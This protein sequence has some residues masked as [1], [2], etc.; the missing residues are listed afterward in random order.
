MIPEAATRQLSLDIEEEVFRH[1]MFHKSLID[2][3]N[4]DMYSRL[5]T[6]LGVMSQLKEGVHVTIKDSY[7]RSIAMVLELATEEYMDPWDVDLVRFCRMFLKKLEKEDRLNLVVIGKLIRMAYTV[8]MLKSATTLKKAEMVPQEEEMDEDQFYDWMEDDE[9]FKV[10]RGILG[11]KHSP[12]A[13]SIIHKGDRPVTLV[14]LLNALEDVQDEVQVLQEDRRRRVENRKMQ[15]LTNRSNINQKVFKENTE[16]EI[17]LT[18]Q[19]IN[20]FNGHPIPLS[21]IEK[22]FELDGSSIFISLLF[23]AYNSMIKVWQRSF[24]VGEIMVKNIGRDKEGLRFGD[25]DL[26]EEKVIDGETKL[27][28]S[29]ELIVEEKPIP[30]NWNT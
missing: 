4:E 27:E 10:T 22:G 26:N 24:P 2:D 7:S 11:N 8:H 25:L 12:I 15:D 17:R 3:S 21:T 28:R 6:Y 9:T 5:D 18:W 20:K 14:D 19:R 29:L 1:L 30:P 23:L 16:E 13:E